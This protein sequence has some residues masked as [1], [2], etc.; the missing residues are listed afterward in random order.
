MWQVILLAFILA[1]AEFLATAGRKGVG[2]AQ[3]HATDKE[4]GAARRILASRKRKL[5]DLYRSPG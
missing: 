3:D 5:L 2:K 4:R 1:G